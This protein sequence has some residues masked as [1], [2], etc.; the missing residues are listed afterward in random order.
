MN[1]LGEW[2]RHA[3]ETRGLT[4]EDAERDTR[5]SRRYLLAL[6]TGEL[7]MIPA[8]VY[9]RGF[10]RSYAQYLGLDPQEAM[11][12]YPRDDSGPYAAP[13]RMPVR[14]Q[15]SMSADAPMEGSPGPFGQQREQSRPPG[16]PGNRPAWRR[17][18]PGNPS[19]E[20]QRPP[21]TAQAMDGNEPMIG[22]DIGVPVPTRRLQQDPA[23]QTRSM[24]VLAVAAVAVIAMLGV[25]FAISSFGGGG[26]EGD[27]SP[28]PTTEGT[29]TTGS[30]TPTTPT[31]TGVTGSGIVPDIIGATQ[32]DAVAAVE[33]AGLLP[34]IPPP[35]QNDATAGTVIE[36]APGPGTQSDPGDP[37]TIIVSGG[38]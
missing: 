8:P 22:V 35:T 20:G 2:L 32:A 4:L 29:G 3:R 5:I 24:I 16:A 17:P 11:A 27:N 26:G 15:A 14:G 10:L 18:G 38:P 36:Q 7:D 34:N 37:V 9:A 1:E 28:I 13:P 33:A 19:A 23:A 12:R 25:A 6:E 21:A 31:T 30:E